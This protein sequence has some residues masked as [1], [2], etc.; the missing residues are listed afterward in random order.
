MATFEENE[1][2]ATSVNSEISLNLVKDKIIYFEH[3]ERAILISSCNLCRSHMRKSSSDLRTSPASS[4]SA[5]IQDGNRTHHPFCPNYRKKMFTKRSKRKNNAI[6]DSKLPP[7]D[8]QHLITP[9]SLFN[10]RVTSNNEIFP[11][12]QRINTHLFPLSNRSTD[13]NTDE[14]LESR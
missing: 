14:L 12:P 5:R 13:D 10:N 8:P 6:G 7:S 2:D 1:I 3:Q 11:I 4:M 9:V